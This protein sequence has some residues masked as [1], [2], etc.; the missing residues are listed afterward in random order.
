MA[1]AL[2]IWC[3]TNGRTIIFDRFELGTEG[4]FILM[5]QLGFHRNQNI[6]TNQSRNGNTHT[7]VYTYILGC[8]KSSFSFFL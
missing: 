1:D 2:N 5:N 3:I 8:P 7:N 4:H 6:C